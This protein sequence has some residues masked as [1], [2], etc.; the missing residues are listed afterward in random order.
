ML[1]T[2]KLFQKFLGVVLILLSVLIIVI[3]DDG[4]GILVTFPMGLWLLLTKE[5]LIGDEPEES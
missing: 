1:N 2:G 5:Q 3:S 4:T